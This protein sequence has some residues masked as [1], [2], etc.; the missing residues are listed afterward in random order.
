MPLNI[1]HQDLVLLELKDYKYYD[2]KRYF[3]I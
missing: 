2:Y 3:V 1:H